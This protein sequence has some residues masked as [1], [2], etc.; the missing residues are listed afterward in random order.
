M[1]SS[2]AAAD[3]SE[4]AAPRVSRSR[5]RRCLSQDAVERQVWRAFFDA[6]RIAVPVAGGRVRIVAGET[7]TDLK[8]D[9]SFRER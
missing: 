2:R 7:F 4:R 5:R 9:G 6:L 1:P 3:E 8:L